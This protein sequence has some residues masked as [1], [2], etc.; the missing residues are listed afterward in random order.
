MRS[1]VAISLFCAGSAAAQSHPGVTYDQV[2]H[3]VRTH[4]SATTTDSAFV[5]VTAT[6]NNM[7]LEIMGDMPGVSR[8]SGGKGMV[9][10]ITDGGAKMTFMS[11]TD[12]QYM[13]FNPLQ[14]MEGAQKMMEGMGGGM[15][16]DTALT[17]VTIDSV[18]PGPT[19]DGH[20]TRH[21]RITSRFRMS[22]AMM[23]EKIDMDEQAVEEVDATP[24]YDDLRSI[25]Q[26][27][28]KFADLSASF[29]F[30]KEYVDQ[31]RKAHENLKGFPLRV[32]KQETRTTRDVA[33][34]STET[35]ETKNVQRL[36]VPDSAFAIPADY[37]PLSMP[38]PG[39]GGNQ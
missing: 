23:G 22:I 16:V 39:M 28:A 11:V 31:I 14:M 5:H 37:K 26:S 36:S 38:F 15:T 6:Q 27:M 1:L 20:P 21:Y 18:G 10:L 24:D 35:T 9:M 25:G 7:K 34:K 30:A 32:V 33:Q 29:G 8:M 13:S 17:K 3:S 4:G 2:I 12:K 19:I